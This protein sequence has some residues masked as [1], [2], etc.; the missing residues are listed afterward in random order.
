LIHE[1]CTVEVWFL[2]ESCCRINWVLRNEI[3]LEPS[4]RKYPWNQFH[5]EPWILQ[6]DAQAEWLLKNEDN[7]TN[8]TLV[9]DDFKW[10]FHDENTIDTAGWPRE[11]GPGARFFKCFGFH[12]YEEIVLFYDGHS[13][14]I[15]YDM[16][17]SKI[18]RLGMV[19]P[20]YSDVEKSFAYAPC[21]MRDLPQS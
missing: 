13:T 16:N 2:D 12:P 14:S 15:A 6:P 4:P 17:S 11:Y 1:P 10:N 20:L 5:Y 8:I 19:D 3:N 7:T 9:K 18:L 21:W